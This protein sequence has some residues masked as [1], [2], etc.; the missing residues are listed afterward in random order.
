MAMTPVLLAGKAIPRRVPLLEAAVNKSFSRAQSLP[1]SCCHGLAEL[2]EAEG[3]GIDVNIPVTRVGAFG[4][5]GCVR[6]ALATTCSSRPLSKS[7]A[8]RPTYMSAA[9]ATRLES[10]TQRVPC[11][12]V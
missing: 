10:P 4:T 3:E 1:E 7:W 8:T 6:M 5:K 9:G 2:M 12:Q 11:P